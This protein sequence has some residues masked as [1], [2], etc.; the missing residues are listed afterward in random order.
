MP[1]VLT[2]GPAI[3][4]ITVTEAKAHLRLDAG[5]SAEDVLV[6]SLL[7]TARLHIETAL[8]L[9]LITQGWAQTLDAW[10]PYDAYVTLG[11][12]PVRAVT[13]VRVRAADDSTVTLLASQYQLDAA[14]L[15]ARLVRPGNAYWP[16]PGKAACGIEIAFSAGFGDAASDVPAPIRQ[17]LL[18]LAAHWYEHRDPIEI[19]SDA[20]IVPPDVSDL[21][22]PWRLKRL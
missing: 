16:P 6:G 13:A 17:A 19:G 7:L 11:V 12:R 10:P 9:A 21:L 4:P 1:L 22:A 5:T 20:T 8:G 2:T 14:S 18:M 15:P 3:E